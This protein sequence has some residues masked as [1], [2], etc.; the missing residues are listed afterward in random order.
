M[1][2]LTQ[3]E[4]SNVPSNSHQMDTLISQPMSAA[5]DRH[6]LYSSHAPETWTIFL[7]QS[8]TSNVLFNSLQMDMPISHPI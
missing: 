4:T 8:E 6:F 5:L 2:F 7:R 3:S 1:I